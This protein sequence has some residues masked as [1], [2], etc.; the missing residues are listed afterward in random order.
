MA[1]DEEL[2]PRFGGI[3]FR[4]VSDRELTALDLAMLATVA[5]HDG[6]NKNR[7]GCYASHQRLAALIGAHYK[8]AA[9]CIAK[10]IERGYLDSEQ[11]G[12]DGRLRVYRVIYSEQDHTAFRGDGRAR[13]PAR[14]LRS[15]T[16]SVTDRAKQSGGRSVTHSVTDRDHA[17]RSD[18]GEI[19]NQ[20]DARSVTGNDEIGNRNAS[21]NCATA[22]KSKEKG[23]RIYSTESNSRKE[24]I[25]HAEA[26]ACEGVREAGSPPEQRSREAPQPRDQ[27]ELLKIEVDELVMSLA[28]AKAPGPKR[29]IAHGPA[30]NADA[31]ID[32]AIRG[33]RDAPGTPVVEL[34]SASCDARPSRA[35]LETAACRRALARGS[36]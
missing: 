2:K 31:E 18:S 20:S 3:P 8:S 17:E 6:F 10:L 32:R 28:K 35:L 34:S 12:D 30:T 14:R 15:V 33:A 19:G 25:D 29:V 21:Q 13:A 7:R 16:A 23:S 36:G 11:A 22:L 27:Q 9:R 26:A 4:A 1:E 5:A 24:R